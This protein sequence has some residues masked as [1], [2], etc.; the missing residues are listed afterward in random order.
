[1]HLGE[2]RDPPVRESLDDP[3]LPQRP[4][5]VERHSGA[6]PA[7][8]G[9]LR[10]LAGRWQRDAV[11][12]AV[13]VEVLVVDPHRVVDAEWHQTQLLAELRNGHDATLDLVTEGAE[14]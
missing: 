9:Q 2:D 14:G 8:L 11:E 10:V 12:L 5:A 13:D 3:H 7:E 6:M 1:M 4:G